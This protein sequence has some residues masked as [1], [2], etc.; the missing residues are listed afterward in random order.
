M[1]RISVMSF[2]LFIFC[3]NSMAQSIHLDGKLKESKLILGKVTATID[4]GGFTTVAV[5][6]D[7]DYQ[8]STQ[9][10][11][12]EARKMSNGNTVIF[13]RTNYN[14][15]EREGLVTFTSA[16]GSVVRTLKEAMSVTS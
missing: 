6:S 14:V 11:W 10:S 4:N 7:G 15:S 2:L 8:V 13:G 5:A 9:D 1:K 16:D 3:M 12:L